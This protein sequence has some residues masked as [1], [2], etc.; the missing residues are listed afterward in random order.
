MEAQ[1]L[2]LSQIYKNILPCV[3]LKYAFVSLQPHNP[4]STTI[5]LAHN[6]ANFPL[7]LNSKG[8]S[9]SKNQQKISTNKYT[10]Y[11]YELIIFKKL[12]QRQ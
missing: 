8:N 5:K 1:I 2:T 10:K 7:P 12:Y 4:K 3:A 6:T 9:K 11:L